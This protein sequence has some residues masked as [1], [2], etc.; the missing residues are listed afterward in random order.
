MSRRP[1]LDAEKQ[2][3][4]CYSLNP[5]TATQQ[6]ARAVSGVTGVRAFNAVE[7]EASNDGND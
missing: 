2:S 5:G 6:T 4:R 7:P 1:E 3:F